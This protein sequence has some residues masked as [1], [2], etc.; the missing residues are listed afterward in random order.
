MWYFG[1]CFVSKF[2]ACFVQRQFSVGDK[3]A[4]CFESCD[5]ETDV[6]VWKIKNLQTMYPHLFPQ[7]IFF[8]RSFTESP[9]NNF[10]R[11]Y[12]DLT[13]TSVVIFFSSKIQFMEAVNQVLRT[14]WP[15]VWS[16]RKCRTQSGNADLSYA[17]YCLMSCY[18][19]CLIIIASKGCL[20]YVLAEV[21]RW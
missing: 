18:G 8:L 5:P 1:L 14:L 17:V 20:V 21:G 10:A 11:Q 3:T 9:N 4:V 15:Q 12:T 6:T 16:W 13:I 19:S 2:S 7:F